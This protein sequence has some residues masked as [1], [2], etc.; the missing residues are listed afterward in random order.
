MSDN[1]SIVGSG[2]SPSIQPAS[3][4]PRA[5]R[6]PRA[7]IDVSRV[8]RGLAF[9]AGGLVLLHLLG[10]V[11]KY[12]LGH[13]NVFGLVPFFDLDLEANAPSWFSSALAFIGAALFLL[14]WRQVPLD[15]KRSRVWLF[16][17]FLFV[18]ISIDEF[19]SIHERL[20]IPVRETFDLSGLLYFAWVVPYGMLVAILAVA[21]LP[22]LRRLDPEVRRRFIIAAIVFLSG[23]VG[24]ELIGG[25]LYESLD[26]Q[27]NLTYDLITT[28]EEIL[29]M[30]GL[31][32]LIR[33]Q[34]LLLR[35]RRPVTQVSL[36]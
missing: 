20:I 27:R 34:L 6:D 17:S 5:A 29:E 24:M 14:L 32:L 1:E 3:G 26:Q 25:R 8:V 23:A 30:T 35:Q 15:G 31:I 36:R 21:L 12:A 2:V 7:V 9:V 18:Y 33:A 19:A 13:G 22:F 11:S 16:L 4:T 28:C 10:L